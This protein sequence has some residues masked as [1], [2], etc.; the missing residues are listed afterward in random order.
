MVENAHGVSTRLMFSSGAD[1]F[2]RTAYIPITKELVPR[3]RGRL[4]Q[5]AFTG[6]MAR[7]LKPLRRANRTGES[8]VACGGFK[9]SAALR[10]GTAKIVDEISLIKTVWTR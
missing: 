4:C 3:T 1:P 9:R 2:P 7:L 10:P 6:I 5:G 8:P